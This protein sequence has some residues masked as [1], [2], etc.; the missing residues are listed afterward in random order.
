MIH[1]PV[2][3]TLLVSLKIA[4]AEPL[5][6]N[7]SSFPIK[8]DN[9]QYMGLHEADATS[10]DECVKACCDMGDSCSIWQWADHSPASPVHSC[11]I[12][13]STNR[14]PGNGWV[15]QGRNIIAPTPSPTPKGPFLVD[16]SNGLGMHFEGIGAISGGGAT[17]KLLLDYPPKVQS[18]ILDYLFKPNFG[19]SLHILKVELGGDSDA[20]E[21][22]EPSHMHFKGDENYERGYEWFL[23]KEA[24]KR[25]P[26]IQ[27]YGLPWAFPGWL[28]VGGDH[29]HPS[30]DPFTHVNTTADYTTK[31][32][33]GGKKVQGLDIDYI[34]LWNERSAPG[35]YVKALQQ[36][37][38]QFAPNVQIRGGPHYPG[39]SLT[40]ADCTKYKWNE[41]RWVDEEGSVA[42]MRSARCLSRCINRNYL[43]GCHTA[44]FQWHLISS[45]YD[46]LPWKRC[47]VAVANTPWSGFYEVTSPTW[48]VAHTT[49]F[50]YPGWRYLLHGKGVGFLEKGG[51]YVTRTN[52]KDFSIVVEKMDWKA[53]ACAR[54]NNPQYTANDE[55]VVFILKGNLLKFKKFQVWY[56]NLTD[57]SSDFFQTT[58]ISPV[59]GSITLN[60]HVGDILTI[61]TLTT[62]S[63]G[64]YTV[65]TPSS[66]PIPYFDN[67]ESSTL[68]RPA[69][70]FYDQMGAWEIDQSTTKSKGKVMRQVV[71]IW[72]VC[73]GYSCSGPTTY[74]GDNSFKAVTISMDLLF[75]DECAIIMNCG[76]LKF[77]IATNG[78][79][80]LNKNTGKTSFPAQKWHHI[81]VMVGSGW[82]AAS[83]DGKMLS[84]TTGKYENWSLKLTLSRYVNA[85]ID[86]FNITHTK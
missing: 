6:C 52:G 81:S 16:D 2:L 84:N 4:N 79:W 35:D 85:Q 22:A 18:D 76:K 66:F 55:V 21:G 24:K 48:A 37:L 67:F 9:L 65:P 64:N 50:S 20:T 1:I 51:S 12:G 41:T 29:D 47:G 7:A 77:E 58:S 82:A 45:F 72:P 60:V 33:L 3:V 23:M 80:I 69:K 68:Y 62:G 11:W 57:G 15:S 49:Q 75:E 61:T 14:N 10:A 71:P 32:L 30:K 40:P 53:S 5:A 78:T 56:S 17:T 36:H 54:G 38:D 73:W 83:T 13:S 70:Y 8:L 25:N 43:T 34:G 44:T 46:Y 27:L 31:W 26:N 19:L 74:F 63:K 42:D 59:N 86:N 28:G 39:T